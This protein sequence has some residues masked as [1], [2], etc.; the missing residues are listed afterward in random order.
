MTL[1]EMVEAAGAHA[2]HFLIEKGHPVLIPLF[3]LE[4]RDIPSGE[5][6]LRLEEEFKVIVTDGAIIIPAPWKDDREKLSYLAGCRMLAVAF[7]GTAF[8]SLSEGWA[9]MLDEDGHDDGVTPA[10][11]PER[12]EVVICVATDGKHT[13][14][15]MW[16]MIRDKP[17]GKVISLVRH[18]MAADGFVGQMVDGILP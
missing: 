15:A 13:E 5:I 7:G 9:K 8:S 11:S 6:R 1:T 12:R 18:D 14:G 17:D 2:H 3:H 16:Q 10:Q 4:C